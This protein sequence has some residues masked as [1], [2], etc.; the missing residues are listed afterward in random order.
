MACTETNFH[1]SSKLYSKHS[2]FVTFYKRIHNVRVSMYSL[3]GRRVYKHTSATTAKYFTLISKTYIGYDP[4]KLTVCYFLCLMWLE[5]EERNVYKHFSLL[6]LDVYPKFSCCFLPS[7]FHFPLTV[8]IVTLIRQVQ[9]F[10]YC[11]DLF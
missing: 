6:W 7:N 8:F 5:E 10:S 1:F 2:V 11:F 3:L 9:L 4:A